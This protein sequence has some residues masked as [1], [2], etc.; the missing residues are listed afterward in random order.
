[1]SHG[2][3]KHADAEIHIYFCRGPIG[4][5]ESGPITVLN[6]LGVK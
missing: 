5:T 6:F 1:M 2:L 4:F 3:W